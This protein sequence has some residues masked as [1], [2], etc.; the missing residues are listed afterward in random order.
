MRP[1][2]SSSEDGRSNGS[3]RN[4]QAWKRVASTPGL[5]NP[6]TAA[7]QLRH[8]K[9]DSD[10]AGIRDDKELA[11]LPE[12]ELAAFKRLWGDV[13]QLLAEVSGGK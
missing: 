8:W 11:R 3:R 12:G 6:E 2:A 7:R 5:G 4:L 10:L 1:P 9:V 13:D